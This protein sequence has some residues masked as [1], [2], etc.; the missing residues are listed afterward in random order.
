MEAEVVNSVDETH[1]CVDNRWN[2]EITNST[3]ED[4]TPYFFE[5]A[6]FLHGECVWSPSFWFD[7]R[8]E[9]EAALQ[10]FTL[11]FDAGIAAHVPGQAAN[12]ILGS[13]IFP[14]TEAW[15]QFDDKQEHIAQ[16]PGEWFTTFLVR[17]AS[18]I[19][20]LIKDA[21]GCKK[22]DAELEKCKGTL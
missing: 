17:M 11:G 15:L 7:T 13:G 22:W 20:H 3:R 12:Y 16:R 6:A 21:Q 10:A 5:V 1:V 8:K 4:G 18:V 2:L 19:A 14:C 9:A